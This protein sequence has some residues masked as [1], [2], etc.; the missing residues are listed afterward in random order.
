MNLNN[1]KKRLFEKFPFVPTKSQK[2]TINNFSNFICQSLNRV[3]ILKGYAGTGKTTLIGTIISSLSIEKIKC[4]LL[5]PTGR[6]AKVMSSYSGFSAT[7]IHRRIYF[8]K[9]EKNGAINFKLQNNKF[10]NALFI[11]DEASM[12][13]DS[14]NQNLIFKN[15][16]LLNDLVE[17]V[18]SGKN[19]KLLFI[20]DSA[21]L[22]PVQS[23]VSPAMDKNGLESKFGYGVEISRLEEVVRQKLD[24]G[25]LF[26]ATQIRGCISN[27]I[28]KFK[29]RTIG[30]SDVIKINDSL[31]LQEA[32]EDSYNSVGINETACIVMSNKRASIYNKQ[33][34]T[35]ILGR[36]S[37]INVD[38]ILMV[39][40]NNYF[41]LDD[42]SESG[43]IANGD[44]IKVIG[45]N[46]L[47][48]LYGFSFA[49]IM[50]KM[51][52][53]PNQPSFN[54]VVMLDTLQS[55]SPALSFDEN[56]KLY[57]KV[58]EDYKHLPNYKQYLSIKTNKYFN[59]LQIKYA[60]AFTCHKSQGGQWKNIILEKPF[61]LNN[62][63][64]NYPRW[65]YTALTRAKEKLYL[66][67]FEEN[68]YQEL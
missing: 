38:D 3:F 63:D 40:K 61:Y 60:Y 68:N 46:S 36:N 55:D 20:G 62:K 65:M 64:F 29:L 18:F 19:C 2:T 37:E 24:S 34:R 27:N 11:V 25:I 10:K 56:K 7:T 13:S 9:Q 14:T 16:S 22:P 12:I 57:E 66:V 52:D 53:Y 59:A 31:E 39:V 48:K 51:I 4:V 45:I 35:E 26:N 28:D 32:I 1:I 41:W 54:T 5:A 50:V 33:I 17:Y 47:K 49:E 21:Q 58:K 30:F 6:A 8:S 42:T 15:S 67:A 44:I 23:L 43:F